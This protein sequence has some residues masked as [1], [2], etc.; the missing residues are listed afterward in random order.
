MC[1]CGCVCH[2]GRVS[3]FMG[4]S[5]SFA[6]DRRLEGGAVSSVGFCF[7][8]YYLPLYVCM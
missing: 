8:G 1:V 2:H 3:V 7:L 4:V 6:F 5:K